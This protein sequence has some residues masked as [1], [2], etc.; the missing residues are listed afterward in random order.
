MKI[1][2]PFMNFTWTMTFDLSTFKSTSFAFLKQF[3]SNQWGVYW[4][5]SLL[6]KNEYLFKI[7]QIK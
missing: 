1:K 4:N 2:S 3:D 6:H 7:S 5:N